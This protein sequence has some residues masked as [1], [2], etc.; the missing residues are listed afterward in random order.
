MWNRPL[1]LQ[2]A[3]WLVLL[4]LPGLQPAARAAE[5]MLEKSATAPVPAYRLRAGDEISISILPRKEYDC[6]GVI[7]P[8]GMLYLKNVGAIRAAGMTIPQLA[9][10]VRS[11][12]DQKLVKPRVTA[13][14]VRTAP[15]GEGPMGTGPVRPA[16]RPEPLEQITVVGAVRKAGAVN[17]EPGMRVRK[18]LDLA[19]GTDT[20]ADLTKV[21]IV[22]KD[23]TQTVVDLSTSEK[24]LDPMQ[25]RLVQPGD[26]LEVKQL[27][28]PPP[29]RAV[30]MVRISGAVLN[31]GQIELKSGMGLEDLIV[32]AG[33]PIPLA[34]IEHIQ[35]RRPGQPIRIINLIEQRKLELEGTVLLEPGDEVFIPIQ[36]DTV[37]LIG[38][39]PKPGPKALKPGN[40]VRDFF[41]SGGEETASALNPTMADLSGAQLIR[42]G[43]G[44][45]KVNLKNVLAKAN[46]P[47]NVELQPGD[48]IF[49]PP[50]KGPKRGPLDY[51]G[52][53][54][55][56]G[57]LFTIF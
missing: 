47:Q 53:L 6:G 45:Q 10:E 20:Y 56:L 34:D 18:A 1:A 46:N 43:Q 24:V 23:L 50:K 17:L 9:E 5:P 32:D 39:V 36:K 8:D 7:L 55:P 42:R 37:V 31:P 30:G 15:A 35:L 41:L 38:A 26:S 21:I 48:V 28:T 14:V 57:I 12:L 40:T 2:F 25:N 13:T 4:M 54:G 33:K 22:S 51:L 52:Q 49:L 11:V 44:A 27:T 29:P 3:G 19:G 16:A